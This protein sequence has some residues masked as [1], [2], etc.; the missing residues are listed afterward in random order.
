MLYVRHDSDD[1]LELLTM[2]VE[3]E[4]SDS[5]ADEYLEM[6][7]ILCAFGSTKE[8]GGLYGR[9]ENTSLAEAMSCVEKWPPKAWHSD[10]HALHAHSLFSKLTYSF[11]CTALVS[12]VL[13]HACQRQA[14]HVWM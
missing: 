11:H 13:I 1:V 14:R 8:K 6:L 4:S 12:T 5:E 9:E 2:L 7:Y 3:D 10:Y